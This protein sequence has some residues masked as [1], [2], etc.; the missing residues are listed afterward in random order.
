MYS[1]RPFPDSLRGSF[2]LPV[3]P[4]F[5]GVD[6]PPHPEF[7][8]Y[9]KNLSVVHYQD[10]YPKYPYG[11]IIDHPGLQLRDMKPTVMYFNMCQL[12]EDNLRVIPWI[13]S[14]SP[15][16][17]TRTKALTG[18]EFAWYD[19]NKTVEVLEITSNRVTCVPQPRMPGGRMI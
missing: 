8:K 11:I 1:L 4:Y 17:R 16:F 19:W 2:E 5:N 12:N 7:I 10:D 13:K 14:V 18:D 3:W 9:L 15:E 6:N